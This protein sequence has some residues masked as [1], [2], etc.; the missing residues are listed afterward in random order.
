MIENCGTCQH[1]PTSKCG[2]TKGERW[3]NCNETLGSEWEPKLPI[4]LSSPKEIEEMEE[5]LSEPEKSCNTCKHGGTECHNTVGQCA[6][7]GLWEPKGLGLYA[8][9]FIEGE[10]GHEEW[11]QAPNEI[12]VTKGMKRLSAYFEGW[13]SQGF[14]P[15]EWMSDHTLQPVQEEEKGTRGPWLY[16][17]SSER[18][19]FVKEEDGEYVAYD[20]EK[21]EDAENISKACYIP[22]IVKKL[23][24]SHAIIADNL[25]SYS[26][27]AEEL[28]QLLA[29][30]KRSE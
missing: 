20:I 27:F 23:G 25:P 4:M 1:G 2:S 21:K 7:H 17:K 24:G 8:P 10:P 22:E 28:N 5:K 6:Y 11:C 18:R 26:M 9:G 15:C 13:K 30:L 12:T 14:T 3:V 29:K 19:Y 16:Y